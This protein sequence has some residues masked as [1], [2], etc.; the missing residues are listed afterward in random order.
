M[1]T[2]SRLFES[3]GIDRIRYISRRDTGSNKKVRVNSSPQS[4]QHGMGTGTDTV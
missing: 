2:L 4:L 3:P 1:N